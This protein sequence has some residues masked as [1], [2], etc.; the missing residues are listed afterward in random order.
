MRYIK[1][2]P[3]GCGIVGNEP[4]V[5]DV[6]GDTDDLDVLIE[7]TDMERSTNRILVW[8]HGTCQFFVND[9]HRASVRI[10]ARRERTSTAH[11]DTHG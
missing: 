2:R 1:L 11:R 5:F 4:V 3:D 10:V 7:H 6:A 8:E 9:H